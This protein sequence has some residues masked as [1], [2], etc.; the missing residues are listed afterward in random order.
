MESKLTLDFG[1]DAT[2]SEIEVVKAAFEPHF[3]VE[4]RAEIIRLSDEILPLIILFTVSAV[5]DGLYWDAIKASIGAVFNA[6]R[7]GQIEREPI[8]KV[9]TQ[10]REWVISPE[11]VVERTTEEEA[12]INS[13]DEYID[14]MKFKKRNQ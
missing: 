14:Y 2:E 9:R 5:A 6:Y 8:F 13:L 1:R 4:D 11:R 12:R 3:R 10:T 7:S